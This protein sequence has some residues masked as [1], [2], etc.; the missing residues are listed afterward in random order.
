MKSS[1]LFVYYEHL[2]IGTLTRDED[3]IYS[4]EYEDE[5]RKNPESFPL[6]ISMPLDTKQFGNKITL[7]FFE[8]LLPEGHVRDELEKSKQIKG[9]FDFLQRFGLD[10]AGAVVVTDNESYTY[11]TDPTK[12]SELDMEKIYHAISAQE[13]V[14][15][16]IADMN[17]GYLSLAGA[18]EKFAAIYKGD[19]FYLPTQGAPTTHIVKSPIMRR[20]IKESVYNE[21]Y[22]MQLAKS[23]GFNVPHCV[24]IKGPHPL[25]VID[26]YDRRTDEDGVV[27]RLHQQ[28]FCQAQ[29]YMSEQKYEAKGGPTLKQ[30]YDLI[31]KNVTVSQRIKNLNQFIDWICFNLFIGN[32]DCHSKNISLL[33]NRGKNE[34]APIY[35]LLSSVMY[36]GLTKNFPY[37]IGDRDNFS[38]MGKNQFMMLDE[39]L[40][41][42]PGTFSNHI[43]H[44]NE[45]IL[46]KKDDVANQIL[47]QFPDVKVIGRISDLIGDRSKSFRFHKVIS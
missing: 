14:V 43:A 6:S 30:N 16:A 28:D 26:R 29:G 17:P 2:K 37:K 20:G 21:Y 7:S 36:S 32:N 27:H 19:K 33:L 38:I 40:G 31:V 1:K 24:V 5:W 46:A 11:D 4:F 18:Q 8:N 47:S 23:I 22:C 44:I 13:S 45:K 34:L 39:Q 41:L 9:T 25:F 15:E 42:K 12:I 10:I 35:D 3:F